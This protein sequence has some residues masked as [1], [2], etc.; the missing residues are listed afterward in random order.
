MASVGIK[1]IKPVVLVRDEGLH[2]PAFQ[3]DEMLQV[4]VAVGDEG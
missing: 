3:S 2:Y 4:H 1:G